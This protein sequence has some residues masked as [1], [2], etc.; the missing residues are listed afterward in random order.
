VIALRVLLISLLLFV[1]GGSALD[2]RNHHELN[3]RYLYVDATHPAWPALRL[4]L[5]AFQEK[6]RPGTV[7]S[8]LIS[9]SGT[10]AMVQTIGTGA[11]Y[12]RV[13]DHHPAILETRTDYLW[14]YE[15]W[16][17]HPDWSHRTRE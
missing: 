2:A 17:N 1:G 13:V 11:E 4:R 15:M 12:S 5:E 16:D 3:R 9:A 7:M 10:R 14:M 8:V 6:L